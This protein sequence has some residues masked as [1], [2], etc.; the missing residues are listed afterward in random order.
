MNKL[1]QILQQ[2]FNC[3]CSH[4]FTQLGQKLQQDMA[5]VQAPKVCFI[6]L[7]NFHSNIFILTFLIL[8][9]IQQST[10]NMQAISHVGYHTSHNIH[11][12]HAQ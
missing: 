3:K 5:S 6:P 2:P 1:G 8:V 7:C 11:A 4:P 12:L 9:N 10:L